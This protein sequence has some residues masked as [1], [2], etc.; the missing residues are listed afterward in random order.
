[1]QATQ[2]TDLTNHIPTPWR[3]LIGEDELNKPYWSNI[4]NILNSSPFYPPTKDIFR[5]LSLVEPSQVKCII[6]GQDPYIKEGQA[7]G[8]SFSVN[9]GMS[10]PPSLRNIYN[11]IM[12]EYA[13]DK[14][15][16]PTYIKQF[17]KHGDLTPLAKQGVLLL[18]SILTV[19]PN[20]SNSHKNIG[21]EFFTSRLLRCLDDKYK[22]VVLAWGNNAKK[23]AM[24]TI[25]NNVV[26]CAGHP[27]P[28]NTSNPFIGCG[29]FKQCNTLLKSIG[30]APIRWVNVFLYT[31]NLA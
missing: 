27:S 3:E 2:T 28:L 30:I 8:L 13:I 23:I 12:L 26:L 18:N 7:N 17:S 29:C 11:E 25:K 21:W 19:Q 10:I 6:I 22:F 4:I 9:N 15:K 14:N 31:D 24:E 16:I 1:M 5:S 20:K